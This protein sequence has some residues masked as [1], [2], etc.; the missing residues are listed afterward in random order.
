MTG[1]QELEWKPRDW[2]GPLQYSDSSGK[3]MM[4]PT[5]LALVEDDKVRTCIVVVL[6]R[7]RPRVKVL[8]LTCRRRLVKAFD[9]GCFLLFSD[10]SISQ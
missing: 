5:D 2:N 4:L 6:A 3:L 10:R 8:A 9:S 1:G 7:A